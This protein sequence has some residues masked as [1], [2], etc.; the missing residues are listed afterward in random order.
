[1]EQVW[2][3]YDNWQE[4]ILSFYCVGSKDQTQI[5]CL[6]VGAFPHWLISQ[7]LCV[8]YRYFHSMDSQVCLSHL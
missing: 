7:A 8:L 2:K 1:M 3:S 5:V 6:V 4:L